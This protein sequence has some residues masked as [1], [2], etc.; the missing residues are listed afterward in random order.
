MRRT[1]HL[2]AG[3]FVLAGI[4][5]TSATAATA[6]DDCAASPG[7][8]QAVGCQN[9]CPCPTCNNPCRPTQGAPP[10]VGAPPPT[11]SPLGF[12]QSPPPTG[13]VV[14]PSEA[15]GVQGAEITFPELRLRLPSIKLPSHFRSRTNAHMVTEAGVAPYVQ[16]QGV[17]L[18]VSVHPTLPQGAPPPSQGA[19][20]PGAGAPPPPCDR[21][22]P[23]QGA[24][25]ACDTRVS[26]R[27]YELEQEKRELEWRLLNLRQALNQVTA[28]P[29]GN[30]QDLLRQMPPPAPGNYPAAPYAEPIRPPQASVDRG[31]GR[32]STVFDTRPVNYIVEPQ[33]LPADQVIQQPAEPVGRITGFR[34]GR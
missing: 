10:P 34:A 6:G 23:C 1:L 24:P 19:P 29:P 15:S 18:G 5:L 7:C 26:A 30:R 20:P 25:S 28:A 33:R 17:A 16:P 31:P 14:G 12:F 8:T 27:L 2:A 9:S 11:Q 22:V 4:N 32:D 13:A 3:L 21:P